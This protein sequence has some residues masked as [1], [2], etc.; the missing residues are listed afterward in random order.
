ML[1]MVQYEVLELRAPG[2]EVRE[3]VRGF[4]GAIVD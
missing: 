4:E 3:E 1:I 2:L